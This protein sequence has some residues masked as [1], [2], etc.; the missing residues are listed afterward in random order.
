MESYSAHHP[1]NSI[2]TEFAV[3]AV[4]GDHCIFPL[5]C[6]PITVNARTGTILKENPRNFAGAGDVDLETAVGADRPTLGDFDRT[7]VT[8]SLKK[9]SLD[10]YIP[11]ERL[12]FPDENQYPDDEVVRL[13]KR[14][15][16]N[17]K[18]SIEAVAAAVIN[19]T[20]NWTN[21]AL[22]S[23]TGG[24]QVKWDQA[25]AKPLFDLH[26][27]KELIRTNSGLGMKPDTVIMG[28]AV[29]VAL[30]RNSE[31]RGLA[32][33]L[34]NGLT[35]GP[36]VVNEASL[37]AAIAMVIDISPDRVFVGSSRADSA[38]AGQS[39]SYADQWGDYL[40]MGCL[41]GGDPMVTE[42]RDGSRVTTGP[43]AAVALTGGFGDAV[44][45][46]AGQYDNLPNGAAT[47][48]HCWVDA[49]YQ[50]KVLDSTLA[51]LVTD[52]VG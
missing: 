32:G 30:M 22:T 40:W 31:V 50:L 49:Y 25:T 8:F 35:Q 19:A 47:R 18:L 7:N 17:V 43:V 28:H 45:M 26:V 24:T 11:I 16:R 39:A 38:N 33:T 15:A 1:V 51:Y 14:V 27:I 36:A 34:A 4:P 42:A 21:A 5:V 10:Q 46:Q 23:L 52:L 48:R 13:T 37:K 9:Y 29:A 44:I 6:P 41:L 3:N 2:L 20:G 12:R